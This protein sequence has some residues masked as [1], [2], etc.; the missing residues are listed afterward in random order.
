MKM[1]ILK[2][3]VTLCLILANIFGT[4]LAQMPTQISQ[5]G[6]LKCD[7]FYNSR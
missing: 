4:A 6:S 7:V 5:I 3:L 2:F 1:M